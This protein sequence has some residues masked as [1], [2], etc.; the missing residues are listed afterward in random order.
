[1][2]IDLAV[3]KGEEKTAADTVTKLLA[4]KDGYQEAYNDQV[5][6]N[7]QDKG[8]I[9]QQLE[10]LNAIE[11]AQRDSK[12]KEAALKKLRKDESDTGRGL[13]DL[14][15]KAESQKMRVNDLFEDITKAVL[16]KEV[17]AKF[18]AYADYI[19]L[20]VACRGARES[21]ATSTVQILWAV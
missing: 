15:R 5:S 3:L 9:N 16:G 12:T 2:K 11:K 21:S 14:R 18:T 1:M 19:D 10:E 8:R 13:N 17:S 7:D 4:A 6:K 20:N